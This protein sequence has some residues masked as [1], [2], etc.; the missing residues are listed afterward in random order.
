M[1]AARLLAKGWIAFCLFAGAHALHRALAA[2]VPL[3][4][5]LSTIGISVVLFGAMGLL[6]VGG[7]GASSGLSGFARLRPRYFVP[8]FNE[9]VFIAFAAA[10]FFVQISVAP[11]QGAGG[12]LGALGAAIRFAV[13]GQRAL[14][15]LLGGCALDGGRSF[16]SAFAWLLAFVFLGSAVSRLRLAAALVRLERKM[17]GTALGAV[18]LTFALGFMAVIGIQLLFVGSAY[19]F[20]PCDVLS[21]L[22][23]SV[24]IGLGPLALAYLVVAALTNL[25]ALSPEA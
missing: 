4:Q 1:G 16:A 20:I 25:L 17:R 23:G 13:P 9:I 22:P 15:T 10:I 11:G 7:Y 21:D 24:L 6:F 8:G 14:E 18:P 19:A 2:Y 12:A 5:A 3:D